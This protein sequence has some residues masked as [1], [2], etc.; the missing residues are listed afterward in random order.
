MIDVDEEGMLYVQLNS[1]S[2]SFSVW[3]QCS[4]LRWK[5]FPF[6]VMNKGWKWPLG[7]FLGWKISRS[8]CNGKSIMS[9]PAYEYFSGIFCEPKRRKLIWIHCARAKMIYDSG[10]SKFPV[11]NNVVPPIHSDCICVII[12]HI[13]GNMIFISQQVSVHYVFGM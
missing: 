6:V 1:H 11:I 5:L 12:H 9:P 3:S 10:K 8:W 4:L 2:F 13:G 7:V